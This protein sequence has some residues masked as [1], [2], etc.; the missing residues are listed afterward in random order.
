MPVKLT[1]REFQIIT[2]FIPLVAVIATF[3]GL[4]FNGW[5]TLG[6]QRRQFAQTE[7]ITKEER[8]HALAIAKA[9]RLRNKGEELFFLA[10]QW[11]EDVIEYSRQNAE[12]P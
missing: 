12:A 1:D 10:N 2:Q 8:E 7:R 4:F 6:I 11:I 9:E 3:F 5:L